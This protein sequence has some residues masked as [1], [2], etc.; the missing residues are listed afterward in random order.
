MS[1]GVS[2]AYLINTNNNNNNERAFQIFPFPLPLQSPLPVTI[3]EVGESS[4]RR[5]L[6]GD[7]DVDGYSEV[8]VNTMAITPTLGISFGGNEKRFLD[9]LSVIEEG[10]H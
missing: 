1:A 8:V 7:G 3:S 5:D 6:V 10:Q 9:L 4:E 2:F